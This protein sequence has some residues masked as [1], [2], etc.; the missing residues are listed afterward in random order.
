[1]EITEHKR[2]LIV[3]TDRIGDVILTTPAV[4]ALRRAYPRAF[5]SILVSPLTQD[6]VKGNPDV[7][8][9]MVDD[10]TGRHRGPAGYGR[11]VSMIRSRHFD[12]AVNF[13][14]KKRTN[15]LCFL[16]GIPTRVGYR[17]K[18]FGFLLTRPVTDTRPQGVRHEARYCLDVLNAVG[19]EEER[20]EIFVP[21]QREA[22]DWAEALVAEHHL[23][24]ARTLL[25]I[26]PGASCPTKRWPARRFVEVI[27]A[28][29]RKGPC[30]VILVGAEDNRSIAREVLVGLSHPAVDLTG[31]TTVAQLA[32]L[33]KRCHLVVSN[34]S[35][36]VHIAAAVGTPV[37]SIFTRNQ[38]GI[39]PERWRPL[40]ERSRY[41]APRHQEAMDFAKGVV[42]DPKYLDAVS[43]QEVLEAIDSVF[44]L[45]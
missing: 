30:S 35:G 5:I 16:A 3:R 15:L 6:L 9:V 27:E 45:C 2:I 22:E 19:I 44:K 17:D 4:K 37:V 28:L 23:D 18:K 1:M 32:S 39:N 40:G 25:A 21:L 29:R 36:P 41:V 33:F 13:H 24:S 7:D 14:T 11:L 38:P 43:S 34:D 31:K 42:N 8:E 12:L 20:M 10:R 26:H